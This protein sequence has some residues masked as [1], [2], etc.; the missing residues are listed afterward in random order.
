MVSAPIIGLAFAIAL[1]VQPTVKLGGQPVRVSLSDLLLPVAIL[2]EI[3]CFW[4]RQVLPPPS[5]MVWPA[6]FL[7]V[8]FISFRKSA[9][10]EGYPGGW[11][12]T[13]LTGAA[14]LGLYF[15]AGAGL[16]Q[17]DS[18]GARRSFAIGLASGSLVLVV[19]YVV[20]KAAKSPAIRLLS[21]ETARFAGL[22]ANPNAGCLTLALALGL[23]LASRGA[24]DQMLPNWAD[25]AVCGILLLGI[26]LTESTS[27]ILASATILLLLL[28]LGFATPARVAAIVATGTALYAAICGFDEDRRFYATIQIYKMMYVFGIS[29][30]SSGQFFTEA[31]ERAQVRSLGPRSSTMAQAIGLWKRAP[32]FGHGLGAFLKLQEREQGPQAKL[33]Q[34]HNTYLWL[35]YETGLAGVALFLLFLAFIALQLWQSL[36]IASTADHPPAAAFAAAALAFLAGWCVMSVANEMMYQRIAW[37]AMGLAMPIQSAAA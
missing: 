15:L 14:V 36:G 28:M 17:L 31:K 37:F 20:L 8:F 23:A 29:R 25:I 18:D 27:G 30:Y 3:A 7:A 33:I 34:I 12:K 13:K 4:D 24:V 2:Y 6:L 35:L 9:P 32:V 21:F 26:L 10:H 19:L 1:Q 5:L 11:A 22:N 16:A